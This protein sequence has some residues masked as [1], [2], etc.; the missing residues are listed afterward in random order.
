[1]KATQPLKS[2]HL[3]LEA[4]RPKTLLVC[5]MPVIIGTSIAIHEGIFSLLPCIL[6]MVTALCI[7]IGANFA[8]D[9]YDCL[10]GA[11]T[12]ARQGP[13]R[14]TQTG[15][16]SL[17]Q[18]KLATFLSFS[19]VALLSI[20]LSARGGPIF[21]LLSTLS[22]A[23]G[24]LYTGGPKPFAYLGLGEFFV[25]VF[26]GPIATA[27]TT[28]LQTLSFSWEAILLGFIP[29]LLSSAVL[30]VNNLR[31]IE[32]D[33]RAHKKTLAVRFGQ[34]FTQIEYTVLM[35]LSCLLP[36]LF[37]WWLTIFALIPALV[38]LK[39]VWFYKQQS[40]LNTTLSQTAQ[41]G[42]LVA[43]LISFGLLM[44]SPLF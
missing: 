3:W 41:V 11:D 15:L 23:S 34:Q 20:Y 2:T 13:R 21:T 42:L 27:A 43:L 33:R 31:D 18:M 40:E 29:G 1:M 38:P 37:G 10:K 24:I 8:N 28:Y 16:I 6:T 14:L 44:T 22:I 36:L 25:F 19:S 9:Y 30:V 35:I 5:V 39:K 7:Q 17:S 4:S 32:E 12:A 26:F